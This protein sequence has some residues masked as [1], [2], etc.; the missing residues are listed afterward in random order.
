MAGIFDR[1]FRTGSETESPIGSLTLWACVYAVGRGVATGAQVAA[2]LDETLGSNPL[3]Q[4]QKNDMSAIL[5]QAQTGT[6]T[7]RIDYMLR[8][9]SIL[10]ATEVGLIQS[11]AT[12]RAELGI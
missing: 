11:E 8:L 9:Q 3:T 2:K 10:I 12:F 5:A 4:D 7:Q 1:V 6:A